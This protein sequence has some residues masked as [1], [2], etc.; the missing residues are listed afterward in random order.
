M[1][2]QKTNDTTEQTKEIHD[3]LRSI[4][5]VN[6][7]IALVSL[8]AV[9]GL[10]AWIKW[11]Y[12]PAQDERTGDVYTEQQELSAQ[13]KRDLEARQTVEPVDAEELAKQY[14]DSVKG[15]IGDYAFQDTNT[16][17]QLLPQ[18]LELKVPGAL[19]QVHLDIV[20]ALT[21]AEKG[22]TAAAQERI[23]TVQENNSW[24]KTGVQ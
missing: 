9:L 24:L 2:E 11:S 21:D 1:A 7:G 8:V 13:E 22:D 4:S 19:Q 17:S 16:A 20:L 5:R 15:I 12:L 10:F 6:A 14:K 3:H 23:R 18:M